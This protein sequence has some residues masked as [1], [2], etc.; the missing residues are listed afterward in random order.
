MRQ[1]N[2]CDANEEEHRRTLS[3]Q[4]G[5]RRIRIYTDAARNDTGY[6]SIGIVF[7]MLH[8]FPARGSF[9]RMGYTNLHTDS[10][11]EA[12]AVAIV[13]ALSLLRTWIA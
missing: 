12:E 5:N 3:L 6:T 11:D 4:P 13:H 1:S 9:I 2:W 8:R 7:L 10:A